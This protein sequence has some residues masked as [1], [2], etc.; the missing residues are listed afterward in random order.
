[1]KN[2]IE[3]TARAISRKGWL[4]RESVV[5]NCCGDTAE[6]MN[7]TGGHAEYLAW[8]ERKEADKLAQVKSSE[9]I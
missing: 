5:I 9:N 8:V 2:L 3:P 6:Q 4:Q 7:N 1:M